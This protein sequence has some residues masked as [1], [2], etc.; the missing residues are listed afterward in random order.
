MDII[1][2]SLDFPDVKGVRV[3]AKHPFE[4]RRSDESGAGRLSGNKPKLT[5]FDGD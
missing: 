4:S 1:D 2:P 3:T 5:D